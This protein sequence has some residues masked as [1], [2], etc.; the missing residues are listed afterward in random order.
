[1]KI[2]LEH[3]SELGSLNFFNFSN[4]NDIKNWINRLKQEEIRYVKTQV[5]EL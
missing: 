1:M 5:N 3:K 4:V 2:K